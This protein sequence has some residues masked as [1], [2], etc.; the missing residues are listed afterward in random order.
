[1]FRIIFVLDLLN[2][3]VVHA[4]RGERALYQPVRN[5]K[6]CDSSDPIEMISAIKPKEV[7][8]AD[9]D[10]LQHTGNNLGI[11]KKISAV[12]KSMV[13]IG[14]EKMDDIEQCLK[15]A[16][17]VIMSSEASSFDLMKRGLEKFPGSIS[18]T[19]DIKNDKILTKDDAMRVEPEELI[20][21]LNGFRV[22]D[23]VVIDLSKVGTCT[24]I[25]EDFLGSIVRIS[26]HSI[27]FG[28]GV[29]DMEDITILKDIGVK[30]AL[31]ATAVH[32]GKIPANLI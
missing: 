11:I 17:T 31:V 20:R 13:N 25:D 29:R 24:G 2:G 9:L 14:I 28:G 18:I 4:V 15:I 30:G 10:R 6:A 32:S 21:K 3:N 12:T 16:D 7:Y 27:I 22:K 26:K 23:I 8:I 1:M 5:S 19:I